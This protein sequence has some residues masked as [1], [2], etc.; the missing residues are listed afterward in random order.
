[1]K[2]ENKILKIVGIVEKKVYI[3]FFFHRFKKIVKCS[4]EILDGH[5]LF[6]TN[7]QTMYKQKCNVNMNGFH[8]MRT[9]MNLI[10]L[11]NIRSN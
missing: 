6:S 5:H 11:G 8:D 10:L 4:L 2:V 1:M 9:K 3:T 7:V